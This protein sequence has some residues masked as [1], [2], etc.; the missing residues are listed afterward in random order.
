MSTL[1]KRIAIVGAGA[2]GIISAKTMLEAGFRDVVV[3]EAGSE[4]GGLWVYGNDN[5]WSV[6]YRNLH[7]NT[8][9]GVAALPDFPFDKGTSDYPHHTEMRAYLDRYADHFGVRQRIRFRTRVDDI[10]PSPAG[11]WTV[12]TAGGQPERYDSVLIATGHLNE[13][14]WPDLP[15]QFSGEYIHAAQYREPAPYAD[16]RVCIMGL[17]NSACD[18]ACDIAM[19]AR[20]V[21]VSTR[22]GTLIWPKWAFGFPLTRLRRAFAW[23]LLPPRASTWMFKTVS[24][25]IVWFV[26]GSME[27][28]GIKL[29]DRKTHPISNQFFLSHVKYQRIQIKPGLAA[30]EGRRITFTDQ[31]SEEFDCLVAATGY[32]VGFPFFKPGLLEFEDTRLPL[33]KRVVPVGHPGLYFIGYFNIDSGLNPVF[34]RQAQWVADIEAGRCELPGDEDMRADIERRRQQLADNYLDRPRLNLEEEFM[35]YMAALDTERRRRP[36]HRAT[37]Q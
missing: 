3:Y 1:D 2:A 27:Q 10:S 18:I 7:I 30:I 20:R 22:T 11:G 26:F 31:T 13:P 36:R 4:V 16:K 19:I 32:T 6:A 9:I 33:F 34:E 23:P 14:R 21:V 35:P 24:K 12:T 29:P 15:G 8:D 37:A 28:Y 5:G 25:L 17:G